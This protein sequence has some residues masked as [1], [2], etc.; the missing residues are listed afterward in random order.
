MYN[1]IY[2]YIYTNTYLCHDLSP[3]T[4]PAPHHPPQHPQ[5]TGLQAVRLLAVYEARPAERE[6]VLAALRA[7]LDALATASCPTLQLVAGLVF[8]K[9]IRLFSWG[10]GGWPHGMY[11]VN[12][13]QHTTTPPPTHNPHTQK[14]PSQE[15]QSKEALK[16]VHRGA[17]LEQRALAA[18]IY[19]RID[20]PDHVRIYVYI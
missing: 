8:L 12:E 15:G 4:F 11:Y 6:G 20:R 14:H 1:I 2:I 3:T 7:M 13:I 18:M 17:T 10:G 16:A 9:V 5:P 19:L